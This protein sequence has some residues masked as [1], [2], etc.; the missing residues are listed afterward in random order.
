MY[1]A[2]CFLEIRIYIQLI[3]IETDI[4]IFVWKLRFIRSDHRL[5]THAHTHTHT[6]HTPYI[7]TYTHTHTH[8]HTHTY[9]H[10]H[11]H[12][13]TRTFTCILL[14]LFRKSIYKGTQNFIHFNLSL[15][16]TIGL[17]IFISGVETAKDIKVILLLYTV[18]SAKLFPLSRLVV[19][20]L[21]FFC[22]ISS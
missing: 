4:S 9:T 12:T 19:W 22:I 20:Q 11:T 16:L 17:I 13:Q 1:V 6:T 5:N 14:I 18:S 10:T 21:Q 3:K 2:T 15:S 7:H 8:T